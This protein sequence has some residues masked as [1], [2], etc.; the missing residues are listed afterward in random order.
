MSE[1]AV[2]DAKVTKAELRSFGSGTDPFGVSLE[3]PDWRQPKAREDSRKGQRPAIE[4]G[5]TTDD[6]Q[7]NA[8]STLKTTPTR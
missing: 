5:G 4:R 1:R 6:E 2:R 7:S 8:A 3:G